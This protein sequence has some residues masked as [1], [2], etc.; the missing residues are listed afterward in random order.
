MKNVIDKVGLLWIRDDRLLLCRKRKGRQLLILPGGK[1]EPGET[2]IEALV[3]ELHE[4][5]GS[6]ELQGA[7]LVGIYSDKAAG[8]KKKTV[9]VELFRGEV[10]GTPV[11]SSE[12]GELIWFGAD[13]DR[14]QLAPSLANK[15][16]P[17]LLARGILKW[18]R[19]A[20]KKVGRLKSLLNLLR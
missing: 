5:L 11:A 7:E 18:K 13:S 6:V 20:A 3:R 4:E 17:D 9:R 14:K 16:I 2:S 19:P 8:E 1:R 15:I 10:I 12:I